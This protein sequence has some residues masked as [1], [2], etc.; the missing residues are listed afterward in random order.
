M[1]RI[2]LG[3]RAYPDGAAVHAALKLLLDLPAYYGANADA[4]YDCLSERR[5][6]VNL[7]IRAMGAGDTVD[8]LRK[9]TRVVE[10]LGGEV[11]V[12]EA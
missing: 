12:A 8:T 9:V 2:Y 5:E 6:P 3:G 1:Q 7:Y 11:T 4:L 10:D